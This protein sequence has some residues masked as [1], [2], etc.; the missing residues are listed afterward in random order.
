MKAWRKGLNLAERL[1]MPYQQGQFHH[2]LARHLPESDRRREVHAVRALELF[3]EL[4]SQYDV[5]RA[6]EDRSEEA[7]R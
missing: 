5:A 4:G 2:E 6:L 3:T 7:E 1:E